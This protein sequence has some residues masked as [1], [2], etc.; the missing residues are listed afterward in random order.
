MTQIKFYGIGGQGVVT[1]AKMLSMAV[2]L[3]ED[4]YAI[5]I[6]SYGHERRGAAVYTDI[7]IDHEPVKMNCC[8]Y[9]PDVVI[10]LDDTI[11]TKSV[12]VGSGIKD[13]TILV[14]NTGDKET[15]E[16][17]SKK[18]GFA[19]TFWVDA[20]QIAI[21]TINRNIPNGAILGIL[22][23]LEIASIE[24]I[25]KAIIDFWGEKVG[26]KNAAAARAAYERTQA[27]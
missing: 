14:I 18:Y 20:T 19:K 6:P 26:K 12:D 2:S 10:V 21:E 27:L 22:P 23:Y 25:E 13:N 4:E 8:V 11:E 1:A 5:T 24:S 9:E 7:I 3:Y 17:Y 16:Y 15:A